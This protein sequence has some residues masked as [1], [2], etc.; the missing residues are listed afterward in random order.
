VK[1][2]DTPADKKVLGVVV[3]EHSLDKDHW[4]VSA[5]HEHDRFGIVNALGDGRVWVTNINGD[6]EAGD[7]I[8]TSS[9]PGYG[10]R[11]NDDLLHS[12][13]LGKA[14]ETINW[15]TVTETVVYGGNVYTAY[16]I[17]VIYTSG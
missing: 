4:Y 9:V 15:D 14:T 5:I 11:Q 17:A 12:Y 7:Y 13:T 6:I 10:Q 16:P 2:S 1:L 3:Q 8:T